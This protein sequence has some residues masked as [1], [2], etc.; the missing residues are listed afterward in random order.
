VLSTQRDE[1]HSIYVTTPRR[2]GVI[3]RKLLRLSPSRVFDEIMTIYVRQNNNNECHVSKE[4]NSAYVKYKR[5]Y[6]GMFS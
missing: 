2:M 5:V 3:Q 4:K 1:H 6:P